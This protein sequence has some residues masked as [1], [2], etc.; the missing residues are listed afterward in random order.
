MDQVKQVLAVLN[1]HKFWVT[2]GFL[3]LLPVGIWFMA[4]SSLDK[5][6]GT[7]KDAI[8]KAYLTEKAIREI[9]NHPNPIS[10]TGM[11]ENLGKL[12]KSVFDA[13]QAQWEEQRQIL[14]WPSGPGELRPDLIAEVDRLRPIEGTTTF[15]MPANDE[16]RVSLR[17]DYRDYIKED[18]PKLAK[19]IGAQWL[20]T[21]QGGEGGGPGVG[22]EAGGTYG[23]GNRPGQPAPSSGA[24]NVIVQWDA[25]DQSRLISQFD[26]SHTPDKLPQTLDILYAQ[27]DLWILNAV[28]NI[29]KRTNRD[30]TASY[31]ATIKELKYVQLG[32]AVRGATG[33][34]KRLTG[35]VGSGGEGEGGMGGSGMGGSG[36]G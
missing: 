13:W 18:L 1:T 35:A 28:M 14:V 5:E 34:V 4:K 27:E 31:D 10:A 2:C 33:T 23:G 24:E 12:K 22:G 25:G 16:L 32:Q 9:P 30:A 21:A 11:D 3:A 19:I 7:R 6:F 26:W 15:P 20:G 8:A 29:I 36:M 17:E